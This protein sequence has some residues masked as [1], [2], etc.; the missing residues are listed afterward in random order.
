MQMQGQSFFNASG[1]SNAY[2]GAISFPCET[3]Y[4]TQV[5]GTTLT[6]TGGV[7][8]SETVWNWGIERGQKYNHSGSAVQCTFY[9][10]PS[11]QTN[12]SMASNQG[13]TT[14][15]NVPDVA[16]TADNVYVRANGM[17]YNAGGTSCASPLWAGFAALA[18]QQ[19][20]S[21]GKSPIG[22]INPAVDA[23][24]TSA[25]YTNAFHDITTGNN[26]WSNSLT[27][28]FAVTGY[29][30]C[31]GWGTPAGQRLINA[32]ASPDPL[33]ITPPTGFSAVGAP[34]GPFNPTSQIF[35][36]TNIGTNILKWALSNTS[37][38]LT[39]SSTS[40]T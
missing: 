19:A 16:M 30:L 3:Y 12:V 31:T 17:D 5:G 9:P 7:Y 38:W 22:F 6:T 10:I 37:L 36:L 18:N 27:K 21:A 32:L 2:T 13:S 28:F 8:A 15:R 4:I 33:Q 14:R 23:I 39:A 11:W 29:D 20:A 25:G 1:D 35:T 34:G 40:G 26:T 24:G